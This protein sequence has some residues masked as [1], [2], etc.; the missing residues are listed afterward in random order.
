MSKDVK[1]FYNQV[2]GKL[3]A[4]GGGSSGNGGNKVF[5]LSI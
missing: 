4:G 2:I 5:Y 3:N 1:Q